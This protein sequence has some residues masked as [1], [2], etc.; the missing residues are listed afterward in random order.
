[1]ATEDMPLEKRI[2]R[3]ET[4]VERLTDSVYG[5][6]MINH[7]GLTKTLNET[8]RVVIENQDMIQDLIRERETARE[9]A[10]A[11][12]NVGDQQLNRLLN[13]GKVLA[14]V[15]AAVQILTLIVSAVLFVMRNVP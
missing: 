4:L 7:T 2:K 13:T 5:N 9:V 8:S 12:K 15:L 6:E 10:A 3:L 11:I 1:M 14:I